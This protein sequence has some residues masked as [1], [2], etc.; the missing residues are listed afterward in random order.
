MSEI[1]ILKSTGET[2]PFDE[3]KLKKS[4]QNAGVSVFGINDILN[5]IKTWVK[6]GITTEQIHKK[7]FD[8]IKNKDIKPAIRYSIRRSLL[9]LGPTGFPFEDFIAELFRAKGYKTVNGILVEGHCISHEVDVMAYNDKDLIFTE[10]KFH[11]QNGFKTDT[12]VALYTKARFDDLSNK[13]YVIDGKEMKLTRGLLVTNTKFT[14]NAIRYTKCVDTFDLISWDYPEFGNLY[15][16]IEETGLLP[17]T[18]VPDLSKHD[19]EEL[20]K[21]GIVN[22]KSLKDNSDVM[23]EIGISDKKI[24]KIIKDIDNICSYEAE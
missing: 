8:L 9:T 13:K 2:E 18:V 3:S 11:N 16:L 12:K 15:E 4:L 19:K 22:C 14:D 1:N 10:I 24:Q 17:T 7:A 23:R 21:R 6:P 20:L 5:E